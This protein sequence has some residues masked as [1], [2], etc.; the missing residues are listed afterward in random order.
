MTAA[1]LAAAERRSRR[2]RNLRP[3]AVWTIAVVLLVAAW[4]IVRITPDEDVNVDPF[5]VA[6]A[7]DQRVEARAIAVTV[8]SPRVADAVTAGAWRAE[9]TWLVVDVAAEALVTEADAL[10]DHAVLIVDGL[11]YSASE[12][13]A[14]FAKEHLS[15]CIP[16]AG[17]LAFELPAD[18]ADDEAVLELAGDDDTRL[19]AVIRIPLD[20]ADVAREDETALRET[21]WA[22]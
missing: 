6:G 4:G 5:V 3:W 15:V 20:L 18:L 11:T 19:D 16:L 10:F 14:S 13:P 17:S 8:T 21:G 9:G 1:E 22:A 7:L 2:P 12:R